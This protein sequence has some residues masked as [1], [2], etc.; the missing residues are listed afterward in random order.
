MD[1]DDERVDASLE[2][3]VGLAQLRTELVLHE[4]LHPVRKENGLPE[5]E[6]LI[7]EIPAAEVLDNALQ[8]VE[9]AMQQGHLVRGQTFLPSL[10]HRGEVVQG[11]ADFMQDMGTEGMEEH[12]ALELGVFRGEHVVDSSLPSHVIDHE[13]GQRAEDNRE[14]EDDQLIHDDENPGRLEGLQIEGVLNE[15]VHEAEHHPDRGNQPWPE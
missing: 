15:T 1:V 7:E 11:I 10:E 8:P 14:A 2:R 5:V 12:I 6:R 3:D 13:T 9:V 4:R